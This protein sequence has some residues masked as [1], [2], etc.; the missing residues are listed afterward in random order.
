MKKTEVTWNKRGSIQNFLIFY[1]GEEGQKEIA[2]VSL[3]INKSY[4][5]V[6]PSI[7][8]PDNQ[9]SFYV[10]SFSKFFIHHF[11][12]FSSGRKILAP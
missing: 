7:I 5:P 12:L 10:I 8:A 11:F 9:L 3:L 2:Y 1:A 4:P 6:P